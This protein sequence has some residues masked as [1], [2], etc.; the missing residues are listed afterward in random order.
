MAT[1][2]KIVT[3]L[4]QLDCLRTLAVLMVIG[5]HN[6]VLRQRAGWLN[7]LDAALETG[8][9]SGVELFFVLSGFLVSGLLFQEYARSGAIDLRRF[10]IRRM[11]KIWPTYYV[12]LGITTA[13]IIW[14]GAMPLRAL[15]IV[16]ANWFHIQNY[17]PVANLGTWYMVHTWSLAVEEHFYLVLPAAVWLA[18]R[19]RGNWQARLEIALLVCLVALP[20]CRLATWSQPF[21]R[22]RC[23]FPTH[24]RA[25]GLIWGTLLGLIYNFRRERIAPMLARPGLTFAAGAALATFGMTLTPDDHV[26]AW[27][28]KWTILG[29]G[30]SGVVLGAVATPTAAYGSAPARAVAFIGR[31]SYSIYLFHLVIGLNTARWIFSTGILASSETARWLLVMGGFAASA[32]CGG[33]VASRLVEFPVLA[34]RDRLFP[35]QVDSKAA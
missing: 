5:A 29:L 3:R 23:L 6:F 4:P 26:A 15:S 9:P 12:F 16:G 20:L 35:A 8:G 31:H 19:W 33:I 30:Y 13:G 32:I 10:L 14:D 28:F 11:F 34:L 22:D 2:R 21:D 18:M 24:L 25:D 17:F 1:P 27:L 7:P